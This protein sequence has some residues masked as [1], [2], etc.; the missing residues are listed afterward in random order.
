MYKNGLPAYKVDD[1][2]ELVGRMI[3]YARQ[4][5]REAWEADAKGLDSF[6]GFLRGQAATFRL[7]ARWIYG[8]LQ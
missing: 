6:A 1:I 4:S 2:R 5:Q 7:S 3:R 8:Q